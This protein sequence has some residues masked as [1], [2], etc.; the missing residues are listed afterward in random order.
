MPNSH[1]SPHVPQRQAWSESERQAIR[2]YAAE[3]S[4]TTW[5][6]IKCWFEAQNPNKELTQSQISKILNPEHPPPL[7]DVSVFFFGNKLDEVFAI[8]GRADDPLCA[9]CGERIA[10][11]AAHSLGRGRRWEEIWDDPEWCEKLAEGLRR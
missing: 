1:G 6:Y 9:L 10:Q 7:P 2:T 3:N 4:G 5:R 11:N 8:V